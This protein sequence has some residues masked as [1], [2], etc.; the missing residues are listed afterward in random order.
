VDGERSAA[1]RLLDDWMLG[2]PARL[3]LKEL[4]DWL[5]ALSL[6]PLAICLIAG[7][8]PLEPSAPEAAGSAGRPRATPAVIR[9][10][11]AATLITM[12]CLFV[13]RVELADVS[14]QILAE[15]DPI[16]WYVPWR[17]TLG[18]W[19]VV[20]TAVAMLTAPGMTASG[21]SLP[22]AIT[23]SWRA[24]RG[25]RVRLLGLIALLAIWGLTYLNLPGGQVGA[26]FLASWNSWVGG[27][28]VLAF[29][30][31]FS[32]LL[33]SVAVALHRATHASRVADSGRA[34]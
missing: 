28:A 5:V 27:A 33:G 23:R 1:R 24:H 29:W 17:A 18:A 13:R 30:A 15:R 25:R 16:R 31:G 4:L 6:P 9:W 2:I 7:R 32:V 34:E 3:W 12:L 8:A 14:R 26:F 11:T 19:I 10:I 22:T 21:G 20:V